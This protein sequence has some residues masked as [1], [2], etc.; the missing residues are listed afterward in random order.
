[1]SVTFANLDALVS[2]A[3]Q[4]GKTLAEI[5]TRRL[6]SKELN[7]LQKDITK[8]IQANY[9]S[10]ASFLSDVEVPSIPDFAS[11]TEEQLTGF[12]KDVQF[13]LSDDSLADV[14]LEA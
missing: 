10:I 4:E 11:M 3:D 2:Q 8:R 13:A 6:S 5:L 9:E 1:M 7:R 12:E 14:T